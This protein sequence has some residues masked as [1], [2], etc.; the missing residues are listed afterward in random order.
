MNV[1]FGIYTCALLLIFLINEIHF[2]VS[3]FKVVFNMVTV[4]DLFIQGSY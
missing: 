2:T 3:F 4:T 1:Q